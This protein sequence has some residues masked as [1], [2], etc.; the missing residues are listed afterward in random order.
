MA[1]LISGTNAKRSL[2]P[3]S[4]DQSQAF[5]RCLKLA[6]SY[7]YLGVRVHRHETAAELIAVADADKPSGMIGPDRAGARDGR[8]RVSRR[9]PALDIR[10]SA[11]WFGRAVHHAG[12]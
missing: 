6:T 2:K 11:K 8:T 7:R 9:E 10:I 4:F 5:L 3:G 12:R 1:G